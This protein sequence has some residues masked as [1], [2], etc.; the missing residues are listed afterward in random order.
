MEQFGKP[1]AREKLNNDVR[2]INE[3]IL[4]FL[5]LHYMTQRQDTDFWTNFEVYNRMPEKLE[6]RLIGDLSGYN[7]NLFSDASWD[8][9]LTGTRTKGS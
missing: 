7:F 4:A 1:N 6:D 5:Y 2:E 8:A 3:D 9:I